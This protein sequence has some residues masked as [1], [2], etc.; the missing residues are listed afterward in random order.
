MN[1]RIL[2]IFFFFI[3]LPAW[4]QTELTTRANLMRGSDTVRYQVCGFLCSR[5][6]RRRNLGLTPYKSLSFGSLSLFQL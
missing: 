5:F 1:E 6:I 4:G 3:C 2:I